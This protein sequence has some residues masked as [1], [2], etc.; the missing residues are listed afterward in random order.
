MVI[1]IEKIFKNRKINEIKLK[2]YGF[3][4]DEDSFSKTI[5]ILN[6]QFNFLITINIDGDINYKVIDIFSMDEYILINFPT[7]Q[8]VFVENIRNVCRD[9]LIEISEKCFDMDSFNG[10]QTEK[11]FSFIKEKYGIEA[12]YLFEDSPNIAV[13]RKKENKKWFMVV[14]KIDWKKLN[15]SN[16]GDVEIINLKAPPEEVKKL[17]ERED[18]YPAYHMNKKHWV[19]VCLNRTVLDS[20]AFNLIVKSY[21]CSGKR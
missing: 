8:G 16:E 6:N 7:A 20:E 9:I 4:K 17:I 13:F 1:D 12:E 11:I 3:L 21:E 10:E 14:M 15:V 19:S 5:P 2:E 18:I